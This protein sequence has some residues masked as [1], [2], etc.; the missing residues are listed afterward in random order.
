MQRIL[1]ADHHASARWALVTL[2]QE[3][4]DFMLVG[5]AVNA[6]VLLALCIEKHPDIV[7]LDKSLPGMPIDNLIDAL[8]QHEPPP[9]VIV[10]SSNPEDG[11]RLLRAGAD[12]FVSK[13]EQPD[14]L[15]QSLYKLMQGPTLEG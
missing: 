8:H 2:L 3:E 15:L 13:G 1:L 14:W 4:A 7:L 12:A 5:E 9:V 10:M 11:R 6:D